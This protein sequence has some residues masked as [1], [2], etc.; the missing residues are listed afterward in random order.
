[1]TFGATDGSALLSGGIWAYQQSYTNQMN[2]FQSRQLGMQFDH[3]NQNR[4]YM[5]SS[6]GLEDQQMGIQ[7]QSQ[8]E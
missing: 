3:L 8:A 1:M 4:Q 2:A 7:W 6:W 5:H